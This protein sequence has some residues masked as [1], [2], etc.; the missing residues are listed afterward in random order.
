[1]LVILTLGDNRPCFAL[2]GHI[3]EETKVLLSSL[4]RF[5]FNHAERENK[6]LAYALLEESFIYRFRH[7]SRRATI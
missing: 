3:I 6:Y 5:N 1:M 2:H 4:L 7:L